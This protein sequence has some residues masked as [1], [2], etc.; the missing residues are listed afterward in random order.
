MKGLKLNHAVLSFLLLLGFASVELLSSQ[1]ENIHKLETD[2]SVL[3]ARQ[4]SLVSAME[5]RKARIDSLSA[6]TTAPGNSG[7][8]ERGQRDRLLREIQTLAEM[9]ENS[10]VALNRLRQDEKGVLSRLSGVYHSLEQS[11]VDSL[12]NPNLSAEA[13]A[14]LTDRLAEIRKKQSEILL[15][16]NNPP[17]GRATDMEL[18]IDSNDMPV[19]IEAKAL[20]LRDRVEI[21]RQKAQEL[22]ERSIKVQQEVK[23][24][25]RIA[26]MVDDV[27]LFDARDEAVTQSTLN[28]IVAENRSAKYFDN[29]HEGALT[30]SDMGGLANTS[31]VMNANELLNLDVQTLPDYDIRDYLSDLE[32]QQKR[33]LLEADSLS[34]VA[35]R[36]EREA[37]KIRNSINPENK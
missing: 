22:K 15:I 31:S 14:A 6:L 18:Y 9:Q 34:R 11:L 20:L 12:Q 25:Q 17:P 2:L 36:F 13:K 32:K 37:K 5:K 30:P 16:R 29:T 10:S 27:R 7:L 1:D 4:D 8:L 21:H 23:L 3:R 24:R 26:D 19:D 33:L 35:D 28:G